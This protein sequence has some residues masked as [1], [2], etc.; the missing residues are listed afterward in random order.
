MNARGDYFVPAL[1]GLCYALALTS[2]I[3]CLI[4]FAPKRR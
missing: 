4:L 1:V 3:W 2:P